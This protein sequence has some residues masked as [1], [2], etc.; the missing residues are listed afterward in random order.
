MT[1]PIS[2]TTLQRYRQIALK[3]NNIRLYHALDLVIAEHLALSDGT[4]A[5]HVERY[6]AARERHPQNGRLS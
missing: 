3:Q 2:L 5:A 6:N 4:M 1:K